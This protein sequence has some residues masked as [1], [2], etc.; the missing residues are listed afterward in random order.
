MPNFKTEII[1]VISAIG[2]GDIDFNQFFWT[3]LHAFIN[4]LMRYIVVTF[5][6]FKN[7]YFVFRSSALLTADKK[8]FL[9]DHVNFTGNENVKGLKTST[10]GITKGNSK[11]GTRS[12]ILN[13]SNF[14]LTF[15][16]ISSIH[17][18]VTAGRALDSW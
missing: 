13:G 16:K 3:F 11:G 17:L 8:Y 1:P 2:P 14:F 6:R 15:S 9:K 7:V 18:T 10:L 12:C 4:S 5:V